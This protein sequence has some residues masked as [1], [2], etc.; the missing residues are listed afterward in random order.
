MPDSL[1]VWPLSFLQN[2]SQAAAQRWLRVQKAYEALTQTGTRGSFSS[3]A[4]AGPF[5]QR[6][7]QQ[8]QQEARTASSRFWRSQQQQAPPPIPSDTE[9]LDAAAFHRRVLAADTRASGAGGAWLLQVYADSSPYC[10]ALSPH[11][12]KAAVGMMG[13]ALVFARIDAAAH[14]MLV[15]YS[16]QRQKPASS[17]PQ[18]LPCDG[19]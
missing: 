19:Y 1:S 4:Q 14:P 18:C 3:A 11:W 10:R 17:C 16:S 2:P 6:Q 7:Q 8:Q 15:S 13:P 5:E 9:S 12:E